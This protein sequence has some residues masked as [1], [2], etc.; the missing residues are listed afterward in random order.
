[1]VSHYDEEGIVTGEV[2]CNR[3]STMA[4][5]GAEG[6][7]RLVVRVDGFESEETEEE[8]ESGAETSVVIED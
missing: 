1:M 4:E 5:V 6:D 2:E 3:E 7:A 8:E